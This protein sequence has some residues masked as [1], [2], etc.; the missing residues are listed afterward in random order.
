MARLRA[1][2]LAAVVVGAAGS[3]A[4]MLLVGRRNQSSFLMFL[5]AGWVLA[6]FVAAAMAD[7]ASQHWSGLTRT[8]LYGVMVMLTLVSLGVYG[9]V[10]FG[11]P[12]P[13]PAALFLI[14][15]VASS[16]A[17]VIALGL[18]ALVSRRRPQ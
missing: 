11:P 17:G 13:R 18:A 14:L 4:L 10:A 2:G 8:T 16:L 12:R 6:P 5:F 7:V 3:V 1:V 9:R 15:P